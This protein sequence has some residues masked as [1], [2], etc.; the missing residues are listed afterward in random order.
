MLYIYLTKYKSYIRYETA[1]IKSFNSAY[2][3]F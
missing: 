1:T 3:I 2:A